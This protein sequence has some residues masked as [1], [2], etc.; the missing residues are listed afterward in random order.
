[1]AGPS[2]KKPAG[3]VY[4]VNDIPPLGVTVLSGLQ[5]VGLV[6]IFLL[7]PVLAC[8][9]AGL[10][11]EKIVDVLA[12]SMLVMAAGP[13]LQRL[14]RAGIGSGYLCPPIFA[15]PYLPAAV[16][17]LQA[18]GLPLM[19]GMTIFAGLVE[20]VV[21]RLFRPLRPFF[22]PEIAGFVVVMIGVTIG[23]LGFRS[24]FA[25]SAVSGAASYGVGAVTLGTMVALNVWTRGASKLFCALIG[26]VAG[27]LLAVIFGVVPPGDLQRLHA[28]PLVRLPDPSHVRWAFDPGLIVPF[29]VAGV[30]ASL[31]AMGDVTICQRTNDAA[32]TRPDMGTISGG[33]L[34]NGLSTALAG[35][36][37]TIGTNTSTSNVGLAAATGVTSR[38]VAFAVGGIY[39]LLAFVPMGAMLFVIMPG[40]VVGATLVFASCL[41]FVNGLQIIASRLLD[42]RRTFVIGLSFMLGLAVDI[43]PGAFSA[44]PPEVRLFTS[45]SLLLGTL[46]ALLL[47][48]VFRLGVR[49]TVTLKVEPGQVDPVKIEQFMETQGAAWG[50]RRDVIDRARFNLTQSIETIVESCEPRGTMEIEAS[51]DEFRLDLRVAYAGP[52]LELPEKR[53]SAEEIVASDEGQRRLAGFLL[54]HSAD[55]VEATSRD[56]RAT[57]LFHFDH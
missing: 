33:A 45:S 1:M 16:L 52:P 15:A 40:A 30:A 50:A 23:I 6:S 36:L 42:A 54:R 10:A 25:S 17:A 4:W 14:G 44:L 21:S 39:L 20:I 55:K 2:A 32:W 34:A 12:L 18:G 31:R 47:N 46:S 29:A 7:V 24:L 38:N 22:P 48:V 53:P 9:Q 3:I 13:L 19:F 28:A 8:R 43:L 49:R 35:L 27:Y 41:V 5:H 57:I 26:M 51:F 37:G 11:P 56:G